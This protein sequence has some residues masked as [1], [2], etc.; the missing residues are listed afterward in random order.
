[1]FAFTWG[2]F[3]R[4]REV[5]LSRSE[6]SVGESERNDYY[7]TAAKVRD[8]PTNIPTLRC[9][10][11]RQRELAQCKF[12]RRIRRRL[13]L[14]DRP[15]GAQLLPSKFQNPAIHSYCPASHWRLPLRIHRR[16]A[17]LI[18]AQHLVALGDAALHSG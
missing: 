14:L 8:S 17:T 6:L 5:F 9:F 7:C 18:E 15:L 12:W 11:S 16:L 3:E 2:Q 1:M 13:R 4:R 10:I